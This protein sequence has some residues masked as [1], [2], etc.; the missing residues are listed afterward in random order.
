MGL[1]VEDLDGELRV[2][3]LVGVLGVLG[4]AVGLD[5]QVAS[6]DG[7]E[8]EGV[9]RRDCVF[10]VLTTLASSVGVS[11]GHRAHPVRGV[12]DVLEPHD[13]AVVVHGELGPLAVAAVAV[14]LALGGDAQ[15]LA[16]AGVGEAD[17]VS[18]LELT[19]HFER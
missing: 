4:A 19:G 7:G 10:A 18:V 12:A 2:L 17:H 9:A 11:V 1:V 8:D 14:E 6:V 13:V 5:A 15:R 16:G 3:T